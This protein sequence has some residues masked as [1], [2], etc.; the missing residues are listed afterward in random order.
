MTLFSSLLSTFDGHVKFGRRVFLDLG[1]C[2]RKQNGLLDKPK[3]TQDNFPNKPSPKF[4]ESSPVFYSPTL[5]PSSTMLLRL[6]F[7][8]LVPRLASAWKK[9]E[10]RTCDQTPFCAR[11]RSHSPHS[12]PPL[13][14]SSL[15]LSDG[16]LSARLKSASAP[17]DLAL[18]LSAYSPGALRL[19]IDEE[20]EPGRPRRFRV[21]DVL[22]PGVED[23]MKLYLSGF[24]SD[25]KS[26]VSEFYLPDGFVAVVHHDP[27]QIQVIRASNREP[28]LSFN[29][30]G[31]FDFEQPT[32][33]KSDDT[34]FE[35]RFRSHTDTRPRGPQSISFDLSFH[36]ADFV[37]GIPEHASTSLSLRPT[38]GPG[39]D[40]S[41]PYRL[42]NLDVFEF[43]HDSPFGLYGSIPF[44]LSHGATGSS[45]GFFWLNSAEMQIDV[46]APGWSESQNSKTINTHW[47]AEAGM[48]D[49]FFFVGPGTK[50][51][52]SQ[53]VSLTGTPAMPQQF[54]IGYHQCRWNYRDEED[55]DQ[56]DSGFDSHDIPYD[57]LWLDIEHTDGKRY[58]TWD[59]TLFPNPEEM[60]RKLGDKGRKMVTIVDP[61]VKRDDGFDLHKEATE[62]GY[63]V[64]DSSG[65]D[66]DGWCWPGS[67]SYPDMLNPEIRDWWSDKFSY[68]NY[69]GS[70]PNLYIWNDMNEP[71]VFNGPELTM[72]RDA[73]HYQDIEHRE[74]HNAYGYYFHMATSDGLLKRGNGKDRPFVLSRAFFAGSQRYGAV[75]TGDN[76]AEWDHLRASV[77]MVLTLGLTGMT[78]SGADVGGFFGNPEPELLVRW[79]QL[80]AFYPFFRGHAHL[81]TKRREP[82]LFGEKNTALIREAI[83]VRYSLLPYFYTL[84]K[85]ASTSGV[86]VMR[87][88]WLEFPEDEETF[89][90]GEA[91]MVG[92]GLY[93]QGVYQA[94]EKSTSAYLPGKQSWYSWRN[95]A[96]YAGG[97]A[98]KLEV[99]EDSVPTF[100]KAGTIIPRKDRFRRSSAQMVNDPYTLVIAL[101]SSNSAEGEL[102]IDDGKSF[103]Y[104][105]G[106]F[107]H[108]KFIFSNNKL[109]STQNSGPTTSDGKDKFSS[110]CS[111]ERIILLGLSNSSY[112]KAVIESENRE[113]DVELGPISLRAGSSN[114]AVTIRKP[115]VRIVDDWTIRLV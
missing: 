50:D 96:A 103:D 102:Y 27:F 95:G 87:P 6:L 80:G 115:D 10:F 37:Y 43:L 84:F 14:L 98:H 91:F 20:E 66:F 19:E 26:G 106:A 24:E 65:K 67:S 28:V 93:V 12:L 112:K 2:S 29:S 48:V 97:K 79:Y 108:R 75:W 34:S 76:T 104:Q 77:P 99:Y 1:V 49:A 8:L 31:L 85:E 83:H 52:I 15:S 21:P 105:K 16:S 107:I 38:R 53:Y 36:N 82:W 60:Q 111:V 94:G 58:F 100:Q 114:V 57:V 40:H 59:K 73:I 46:L 101:D 35:E 9:D 47:M 88:L 33:N 89:N 63:Y 55:V 44:M 72:P 78:F 5:L 86:P 64:K 74:V 7:L 61:H 81:D 90:N 113:V 13:S 51:V 42:F 70:T 32:S 22:I 4:P 62:K 71:S 54:S 69:K 39:T 92:P 109:I 3:K 68:E 30:H 56:V 17:R 11:A 25:A 110:D 41:E 23:G 18:R 45:S